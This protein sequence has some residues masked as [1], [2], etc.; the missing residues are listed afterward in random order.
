MNPIQNIP[1]HQ[2]QEFMR[3]LEEL[4]VQDSLM[5]VA[6]CTGV[7]VMVI[8]FRGGSSVG[9]DSVDPIELSRFSSVCVSPWLAP[10]PWIPLSVAWSNTIITTITIII[11]TMITTHIR[12]PQNRMYNRLVER[13]FK[14]C[15]TVRLIYTHA[16]THLFD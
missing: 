4:Q 12:P 13:C 10:P 9:V 5:C 15:V 7:C 11:I 6:Q 14:E 1:P 8:R 3:T 2:R 16:H